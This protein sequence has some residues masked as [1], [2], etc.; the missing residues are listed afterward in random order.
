M[1]KHAFLGDGPTKTEEIAS[2]ESLNLVEELL[3]GSFLF[4]DAEYVGGALA[5]HILEGPANHAVEQ[6]RTGVL[7]ESGEA[8]RCKEWYQKA[9]AAASAK[10]DDCIRC[11]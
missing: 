2:F 8:L 4:G 1:D 7:A 9:L 6:H 10:A 11:R 3:H 5:V